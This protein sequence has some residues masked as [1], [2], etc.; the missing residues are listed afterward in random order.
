MTEPVLLA[1][2]TAGGGRVA[3][4]TL[5]RPG[6]RNAITIELA[7]ALRD[8]LAEAA[9]TAEV[10][11]I[12]GAGGDFCTGGDFH[13]VARLREEGPEALRPLFET[14]VGACELIA[15]LPVPVV[16]AVEGY[17]MAGGFELIQS[18]DVAIVRD[19][20]VLADNHANFGM[21]PGGGG[22]QRL[23]RILGVPRAMGHILLGDRLTGARAADWGL[24]YRSAPPEEFETAVEDVVANLAA[25]DRDALARIKHLVRAGLRGSLTDGLAME[26]ESTLAHLGGER[27][28]AG[29]GRFTGRERS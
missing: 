2:S 3:H 19:D 13:E 1:Y 11:V 21:I 16:A 15:E 9:E 29:I 24:V 28:G 12:R 27:A 5:N 18:V 7:A 17:A 26:V 8:R 23:P 6:A 25:K 4:V 20:A 14:F 10:V 22:S